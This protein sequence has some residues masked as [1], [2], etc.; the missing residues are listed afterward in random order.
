MRVSSGGGELLIDLDDQELIARAQGGDADAYGEIVRRYQD[1]AFRVA[2]LQTNDTLEA[3]DAAQGGFIKAY[4]ALDRFDKHRPFRPWLLTIVTNEAR[5][6]RA[7]A[8][9]RLTLHLNATADHQLDANAPSPEDDVLAAERHDTL[10]EAINALREEDRVIIAY[11]YFLDLSEAET[12]AALACPRGTVKSRLARA[13]Q[14]LRVQIGTDA[15][16]RDTLHG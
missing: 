4:D 1:V 5:N 3:E 6:R 15:T 8:H 2:Y 16:R 7:A 10:L 14:R 9:R 11:R 12:A 13:L